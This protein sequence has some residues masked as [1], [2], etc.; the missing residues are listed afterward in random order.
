MFTWF[1]RREQSLLYLYQYL[2]SRYRFRAM[3]NG[4]LRLLGTLWHWRD[5]IFIFARKYPL[6]HVFKFFRLCLRTFLS[7]ALV[8]HES[9]TFR[10]FHFI[11]VTI[12]HFIFFWCPA[13]VAF[14]M[15]VVG[16]VSVSSV[17]FRGV[18]ISLFIQVSAAIFVKT[19]FVEFVICSCCESTV[20]SGL[21]HFMP[22]G[23]SLEPPFQKS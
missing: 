7:N 4:A 16:T 2:S 15:N 10:C 14:V 12:R 21:R 9:H 5:C 6:L 19:T 8:S 1:T 18:H 23:N 17:C 22:R 11:V 20:W 3:H 13:V